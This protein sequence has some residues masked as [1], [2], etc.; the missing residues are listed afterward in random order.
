MVGVGVLV[1]M[2]LGFP[3]NVIPFGA[4]KWVSADDDENP[5]L[6]LL[7]VS[8]S[9]RFVP[10]GWMKFVS[11]SCAAEKLRHEVTLVSG[12]MMMYLPYF[13]FSSTRERV[14]LFSF[15]VCCWFG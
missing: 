4:G 7:C 3:S 12:R 5:F 8:F 11:F 15:V 10:F 9:F 13:R 6:L 2:R 14:T 1:F